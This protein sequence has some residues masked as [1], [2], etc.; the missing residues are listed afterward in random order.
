MA[1]HLSAQC[2]RQIDGI[3]GRSGHGRLEDDQAAAFARQFLEGERQALGKGSRHEQGFL[4][5][6]LGTG[7]GQD[8]GEFG[9]LGA[10]HLGHVDHADDQRG[11]QDETVVGGQGGAHHE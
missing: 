2:G 3:R 9:F 11:A 4:P 10:V 5:V 1:R 6:F 7:L 8:L